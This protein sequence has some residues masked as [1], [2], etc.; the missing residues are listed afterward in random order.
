[1]FTV[2]NIHRSSLYWMVHWQS[3]LTRARHFFVRQRN[4]GYGELRILIRGRR[5]KPIILLRSLG[6]SWS[7]ISTKCRSSIFRTIPLCDRSWKRCCPDSNGSEIRT[8]ITPYGARTDSIEQR[9]HWLAGIRTVASKHRP[10]GHGSY[11][12]S[13]IAVRPSCAPKSVKIQG[14]GRGG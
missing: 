14:I 10:H 1:M 6:C 7:T 8:I 12:S 9:P 11:L 2:P 5:R 3:I 4:A 13:M